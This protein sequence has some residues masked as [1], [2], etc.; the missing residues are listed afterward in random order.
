[1]SDAKFEMLLN[2]AGPIIFAIFMYLM[3][4]FAGYQCS[5]SWPEQTTKYK[6]FVGCMV[7]VD[8]KFIPE[9]NYRV[10]P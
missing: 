9:I 6:L 10:L 7:E 5:I 1:M 8:G 4:L 2:M 3:Y